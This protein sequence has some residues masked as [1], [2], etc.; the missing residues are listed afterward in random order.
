MEILS[1]INQKGGVGKTTTALNLTVALRRQNKKV[2][3]IDLDPQCNLTRNLN[4]DVKKSIYDVL[5]NKTPIE[6]AIKNDFVASSALMANL[7][8]SVKLR[9][10]LT[11]V[12][13]NYDFIIIDTPP[14][15]GIITV[16]ALIASDSLIITTTADAYSI[17][18]ITQLISTV[19]VIR[20]KSNANLIIR[21]ILI[22]RYVERTV[23]A[24]NVYSLL[25]KIS[26]KTG[27]KLLKTKIRECIG[28]REAPM[29]SKDIFAYS[30]YSNGAF[31]YEKLAKEILEGE[32][33]GK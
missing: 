8:T 13:T 21:G 22:T 2:L 11:K 10:I 4:Y 23:L 3:L 9:A 33:D 27:I 5:V 18:G 12:K 16:M 17:Q 24:R 20:Q 26:H 15:L 29:M 7:N 1:I 28:L 25:E 32:T 31:D 6:Q 14:S 19:V 30:R